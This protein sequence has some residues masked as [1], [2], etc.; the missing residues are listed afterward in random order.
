M[1]R[2]AALALLAPLAAADV[3]SVEIALREVVAGGKEF[4]DAGAYEKLTGTIRFAFDPANEHNAR[5]VDLDRAPR[6]EDGL[7]EAWGDLMVLRPVDASKGGGTALLEV[8]NRG[9]KASLSYFNGGRRSSDPIDEAHFGDGFLMRRGLT[10]IWVG[11]QWDVP[12][13]PSRLRLH[14][15]A[16]EGVEGLVRADWTVARASD[17]LALGHRN[18]VAYPPLDPESDENVLTERDGRLAERRVVPRDEWSFDGV[19]IRREGGFEAGRIYELVY[20]AANPR[21]VGLG[22]AA[23]RDTIAYAKHDDECPFPVERGLAV[24]ISQTGRFLRHFLYQGFNTDEEGRRAFDGLLIHTAGAGRGSFNHRFGQPSRDAHRYSAFFYPTDLFPFSG[25]AQRDPVTKKRDG[26]LARHE[27]DRNAP[28]VFYTNTGYEYWGR[29]ASLL[30]TSLDGSADVEALANERIYH[31][32][33]TQH[34]PVPFPPRQ[35]KPGT[36]VYRGNPIDLLVPLRALLVALQEWVEDDTEP[37]PSRYPRV[38]DGTLVPIDEVAWPAID[39]LDLPT[40]VHEAY[41]ADYGPEW[42]RG[43]VTKQ[44]PELGPAFPSLVA[45]VDEHGNE[46][47]GVPTVEILAP[48]GTYLPWNLRFG[49]P[50]EEHELNDFFGTFVPFGEERVAALYPVRDPYEADVDRAILALADERFLLE[51]D[52]ERVRAAALARWDWVTGR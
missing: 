43:V 2:I 17:T 5:I 49:M 8:S 6:S 40:V 52:V 35:R 38:A 29:A 21:V 42:E 34:F 45:Q 36:Q 15:P 47:A 14:V 51:E 27:A 10:V 32:A 12:E 20:R 23:V 19:A 28:K 25:R 46:V 13:D 31:L 41:R 37:P 48:L 22:L 18:H 39:G 7:V 16:I 44:P 4:G 9:G 33:S 26:I 3:R 24:G 11:W 1:R 50:G 30:H